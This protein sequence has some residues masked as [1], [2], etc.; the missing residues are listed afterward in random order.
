MVEPF[1][2]YLEKHDVTLH[3]EMSHKNNK[4]YAHEKESICNCIGAVSN[5]SF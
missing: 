2:M 5:G 1:G 3:Q 4:K